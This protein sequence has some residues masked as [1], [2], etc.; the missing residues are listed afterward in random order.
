MKGAVFLVIKL[1]NVS[2]GGPLANEYRN[3]LEVS[4]PCSQVQATAARAVRDG[5][6]GTTLQQKT[7]SLPGEREIESERERERES[8]DYLVKIDVTCLNVSM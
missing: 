1:V 2:S 6:G 4:P 7:N 3:D 8:E 5:R